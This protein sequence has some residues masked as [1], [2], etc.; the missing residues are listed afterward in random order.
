[1]DYPRIAYSSTGAFSQHSQLQRLV[2]LLCSLTQGRQ[3]SSI[4][5]QGGKKKKKAHSNRKRRPGTWRQR[6]KPEEE[7][8]SY[9]RGWKLTVPKTVPFNPDAYILILIKPPLWPVSNK[10]CWLIPTLWSRI[11]WEEVNGPFKSHTKSP[12][13]VGNITKKCLSSAK[14]QLMV[15]SAPAPL[16]FCCYLCQTLFSQ[17][18][19]R[20]LT[21]ESHRSS[22]NNDADCPFLPYLLLVR[23]LTDWHA[24]SVIMTWFFFFICNLIG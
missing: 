9:Q 19:T 13:N 3:I 11:G 18:P 21:L 4:W 24:A 14:Q 2:W 10:S 1:M 17:N 23:S 5:R 15:C 22:L 7:V 16:R 6:G 8:S 20:S 12:Q